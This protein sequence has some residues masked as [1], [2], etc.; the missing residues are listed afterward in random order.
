MYKSLLVPVERNGLTFYCAVNLV[1]SNVAAAAV[2]LTTYAGRCSC[3][4]PRL[5]ASYC[6]T[7]NA[8]IIMA[9][10]PIIA[11]NMKPCLVVSGELCICLS[12]LNG[13]LVSYVGIVCWCEVFRDVV[14][15]AWAISL[16]F[17]RNFWH[18]SQRLT[19]ILMPWGL[20][21]CRANHLDKVVL[22]LLLLFA[23]DGVWIDLWC[24]RYRRSDLR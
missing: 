1:A 11:S 19:N 9:A 4:M 20:V 18:V 22:W 6:P 10:P 16:L 14:Y 23:R 13:M 24:L 3:N 8:K 21:I 7:R 12:A 15:P 5:V 17:P 2:S